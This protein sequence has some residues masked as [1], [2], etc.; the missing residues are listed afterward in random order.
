MNINAIS[1]PWTP[2][3]VKATDLTDTDSDSR[4]QFIAPIIKSI[5]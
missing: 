1:S 3:E 2:P 4:V 5:G